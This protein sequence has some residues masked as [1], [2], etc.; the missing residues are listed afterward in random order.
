M[1]A[2]QQKT[3]KPQKTQYIRPL[4]K[5]QVAKIPL[6]EEQQLELSN[7]PK[8]SWVRFSEGIQT[9]SDW[10]IITFR[11]RV[12]KLVAQMLYE[13]SV[14]EELQKGVDIT[15]KQVDAYFQDN[16]YNWGLSKD[17]LV[18]ILDCLDITTSIF[19]DADRETLMFCTRK[20]HAQLMKYV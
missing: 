14:N 13:Q 5:K 15:Q 7:P 16:T 20:V 8:T 6:S 12:G 10:Y 11:I 2:T 9:A 17:E 4:T 3:T 1:Q 18:A 19:K